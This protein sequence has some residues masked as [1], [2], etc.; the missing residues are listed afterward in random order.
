MSPVIVSSSSFRVLSWQTGVSHLAVHSHINDAFTCF[1]PAELRS[2]PSS[3]V[4]FLF[5][6]PSLHEL[7]LVIQPL[8][9]LPRSSCHF[10]LGSFHVRRDV[11]EILDTKLE[12]R[13]LLIRPSFTPLFQARSSITRNHHKAR[14]NRHKRKMRIL[15]RINTE[16]LTLIATESVQEKPQDG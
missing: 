10:R 16:E 6:K 4:H 12:T 8:H 9:F 1:L 15:I 7:P 11:G 5:H 3:S 14:H 2:L 13:L